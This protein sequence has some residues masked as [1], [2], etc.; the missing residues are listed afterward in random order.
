M[1][2]IFDFIKKHRWTYIKGVVLLIMINALQLAIPR[3]T[4]NIIDSL[5]YKTIDTKGLNIYGIM[6]IVIALM[7]LVLHYLSRFYLIGAA[8]L[9]EYNMRNKLF[10]HLL[11]LSMKFFDKK[12]VGELMALSVNDMQA[13]RMAMM[14]GII[15]IVNTAFLLIASVII[16]SSTIDVRLTIIAFIPFPILII[17]MLKFGKVINTRFKMVQQSFADLT[18]VAQENISGIRVIKAFAQEE[19][20]VRRFKQT[21]EK[22]Y[23]INMSLVK[24]QGLFFPLIHFITSCSFLI[25]LIV[26]GNMVITGDITLGDF[27]AFNSY[28]GLM[29]R[30]IAFIGMIINFIQRGK[31]SFS[32]IEQLFAEPTAQDTSNEKKACNITKGNIVFQNLT[33]TYDEKEKPVLK[34]IHLDITQGKTVG[35]IGKIGSGKSTVANLILKTYSPC[36]RGEILI[37]GIDILDIPAQVLREKVG[38]VPQENFLFSDTIRE[39]IAFTTQSV[40]EKAMIH[41]TKISQ[42]YDSIALLPKAFDTMLG[43]KGVNLSGGQKQRISIA[44]ALIK[45]PDILILDDCLSAVDTNTEKCLIEGL[46]QEMEE[47]TCVI[48]A[49]RISTVQ[50]ADEIVVLHDGCIVEKGTHEGL[51]QKQGHYYEIYQQQLLDEAIN[52]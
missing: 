48:I 33:F 37:D 14:R 2:R 39:N 47:K 9:F 11:S 28:I 17:V 34:N 46:K 24:V 26:G 21:N 18:S 44:R 52:N 41:A 36:Q 29:I 42:I 22:N 4:G 35:I 7:I 23:Q 1:K 31:A 15:M 5:Q 12:S 3:I 32:R 6:I 16:L 51:L 10:K 45:R 13:I 8:N 30:P 49:H 50:Y 43:E 20:E 40:S 25:A 27:I 19:E 38:Y